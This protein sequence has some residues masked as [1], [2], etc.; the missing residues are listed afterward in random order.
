L[1]LGKTRH[2]TLKEL[3]EKTQRIHPD[4]APVYD[5]EIFKL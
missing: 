4:F 3:V 5:K 1:A 2:E